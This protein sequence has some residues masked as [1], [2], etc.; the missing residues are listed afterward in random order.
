MFDATQL[1]WLGTNACKVV[2]WYI[3]PCNLH[4][5]KRTP[6]LHHFIKSWLL[7]IHL[8]MVKAI[9]ISLHFGLVGLHFLSFWP[10]GPSFPFILA[11]WAFISFHFLHF[12]FLGL[13]FL[14]FWPCGPKSKLQNPSIDRIIYKKMCLENK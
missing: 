13:H 14:S 3:E 12:G 5:F 1:T 9:F 7:G 4:C 11:V 8:V 10:C 2:D 6:F